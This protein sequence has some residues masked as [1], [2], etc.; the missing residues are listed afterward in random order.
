MFSLKNIGLLPQLSRKIW[1]GP[2]L[3]RKWPS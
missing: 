2:Q 3:H 1:L